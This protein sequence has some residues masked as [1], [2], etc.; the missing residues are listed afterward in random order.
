MGSQSRNRNNTRNNTSN[1]NYQE[2]VAKTT[3]DAVEQAKYCYDLVNN[4]IGNADN[5][6]SVSCVVFTGG[7]GVITF[8]SE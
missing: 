6:V 8:L 3:D 2:Q 7:F 1:N 5:K 4:W